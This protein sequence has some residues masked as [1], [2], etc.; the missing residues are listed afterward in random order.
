MK[1]QFFLFWWACFVLEILYFFF[2]SQS[3]CRK[4]PYLSPRLFDEKFLCFEAKTDFVF[5]SL[6]IRISSKNGKYFLQKLPVDTDISARL[7]VSSRARDRPN[8][9]TNTGLEVNDD[10][11]K[12]SREGFGPKQWTAPITA[13]RSA[14][15]LFPAF[16]LLG[17]LHGASCS[18]VTGIGWRTFGAISQM[19]SSCFSPRRN[20]PKRAL[21]FSPSHLRESIL[22]LYGQE[23]SERTF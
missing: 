11:Q 2:F 9:A 13:Y 15:S 8:T 18:R 19:I 5:K 7:T 23:C 6:Y 17:D 16:V 12:R 21:S 10:P 4:I 3:F 20:S 22:L 14:L 1:T